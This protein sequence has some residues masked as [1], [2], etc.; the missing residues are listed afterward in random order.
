MVSKEN[1]DFEDICF[2]IVSYGSFTSL[3]VSPCY[4]F[5]NMFI[6]GIIGVTQ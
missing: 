5:L 6:V 4:K 2:G 3:A 1:V